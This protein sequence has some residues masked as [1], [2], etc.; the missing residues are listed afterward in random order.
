[1]QLFA[2]SDRFVVLDATTV[3]GQGNY[4]QRSVNWNKPLVFKQ[5]TVMVTGYSGDCTRLGNLYL[6]YQKLGYKLEED[7]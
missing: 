4:Y 2:I 5:F 6:K 7:T 1:M 3:N